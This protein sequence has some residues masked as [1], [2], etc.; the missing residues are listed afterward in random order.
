MVGAFCEIGLR[1]RAEF[2]EF[3]FVA[4]TTNKAVL[5]FVHERLDNPDSQAAPPSGGYPVVELTEGF[6]FGNREIDTGVVLDD[7]LEAIRKANDHH[8]DVELRVGRGGRLRR[9]GMFD[10]VGASFSDGH[11]DFHDVLV[12]QSGPLRGFFNHLANGRQRVRRA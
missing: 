6:G 3:E 12:A 4:L 11:L 10:D 7:N 8:I 9:V 1:L 5:D 2:D